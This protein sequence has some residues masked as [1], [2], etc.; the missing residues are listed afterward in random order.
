MFFHYILH[1]LIMQ[2][3]PTGEAKAFIARDPDFSYGGNSKAICRS[4]QKCELPPYLAELNI[5]P[6]PHNALVVPQK[7]TMAFFD[8]VL[9]AFL[10]CVKKIQSRLY[11]YVATAHTYTLDLLFFHIKIA[12]D[13]KKCLFASEKFLSFG[14]GN[15]TGILTL[16]SVINQGS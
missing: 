2:I 1:V 12:P 8:V 16:R 10:S 13:N 4:A 3:L 9:L 15:P 6:K 5:Q 7:K 14:A 11:S